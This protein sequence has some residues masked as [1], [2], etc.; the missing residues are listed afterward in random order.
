VEGD[1]TGGGEGV[2]RAFGSILGRKLTERSLFVWFIRTA[3]R[4]GFALLVG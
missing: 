4:I 3:I 2:K 1:D